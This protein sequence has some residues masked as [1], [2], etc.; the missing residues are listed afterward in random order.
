MGTSPEGDTPH[1][2]QTG[3]EVPRT[4]SSRVDEAELARLLGSARSQ[5]S[6]AKVEAEGGGQEWQQREEER[7]PRQRKMWQERKKRA[8]QMGKEFR[9]RKRKK[10]LKSKWHHKGQ[11]NQRKTKMSERGRHRCREK[12]RPGEMTSSYE[13]WSKKG[14]QCPELRQHRPSSPQGP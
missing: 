12:Q 14:K 13:S 7:D 9:G 4:E 6:S 1:F 2:S 10:K 3:A 11:K 8:R 5:L